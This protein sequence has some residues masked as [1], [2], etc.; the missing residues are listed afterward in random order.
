MNHNKKNELDAI[1]SALSI[2]E[3]G[4]QMINSRLACRRS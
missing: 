4:V 1:K 3:D 2:L